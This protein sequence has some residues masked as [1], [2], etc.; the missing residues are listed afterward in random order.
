MD[1]KAWRIF[2]AGALSLLLIPLWVGLFFA[3]PAAPRPLPPS[4]KTPPRPQEVPQ[5]AVDVRLYDPQTGQIQI[6][7]LDDYVQGVVAAEMKPGFH[8]EALKAQAVAARSYA[9]LHLKGWGGAGCPQQPAADICADS[10]THQA[11]KAVAQ[12]EKAEPGFLTQVQ[13]AVEATRGWVLT[14]RGVVAETTF[15]AAS[16]GRTEDAREVWHRAVPYLVSVPSP[17]ESPYDG[18]KATFMWPQVAAAFGLPLSQFP[19]SPSRRFQIRDY[20]A[21]GRTRTVLVGG[22]I[23]SGVEVRQRL[24][25]RSTWI[26]GVEAT[27]ARLT[28]TTRGW[29]HGVGLSQYGAQS[30]AQKGA[31]FEE[32]LD[33]YYPGT[34]LTPLAYAQPPRPQ[35]EHEG[36]GAG[37]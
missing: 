36:E 9:V 28:L 4:A 37:R 1:R 19:A 8:L 10:Q 3:L 18:E 29:G 6:L 16:G 24:G 12:D 13:E 11:W 30:M 23:F 22:E 2:A 7:S 32:I 26:V 15:Y 33:H 25:L 35:T 21:G 20:T 34:Q 14:Y 5:V 17:E 31:T 27:D